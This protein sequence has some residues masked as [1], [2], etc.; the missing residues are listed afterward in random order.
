MST[1]QQQKTAYMLG[2]VDE[3]EMSG[4]IVDAFIEKRGITKSTL[5]YWI[6]KKRELT[7]TQPRFVELVTS[8]V[9]QVSDAGP[10][11]RKKPQVNAQ[12]EFTLPNGLSIK[13]FV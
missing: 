5:K 3:F 2:M 13:V 4:Q 11:N 8:A 1:S 12:I 6:R 9:S 7:R 10:I